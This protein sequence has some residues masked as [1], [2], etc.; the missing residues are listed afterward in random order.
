MNLKKIKKLATVVI[1]T[2]VIVTATG[3]GVMASI[4]PPIVFSQ[5]Q[6]K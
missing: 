1:L 3:I 6:Q 5:Q 2:I 4:D